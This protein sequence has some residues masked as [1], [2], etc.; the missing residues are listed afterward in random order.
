MITKNIKVGDISPTRDFTFVQDTCQAFLELAKSKKTIGETINIGTNVEVSINDLISLI[1]D[2]TNSDIQIKTEKKRKRPKN[3]EVFRLV[4]DSTKLKKLTGFDSY[5]NLK[6]GLIE[7][8]E[9]FSIPGN[10]SKYKTDIY[11]V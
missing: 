7:T 6:E 2:V 11:N 4:C 8:V 1:K 9:W 3:S 10:L 5:T